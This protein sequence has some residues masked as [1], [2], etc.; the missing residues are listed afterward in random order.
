M[1]VWLFHATLCA[2]SL[3]SATALCA[4]PDW[5]FMDQNG[6]SSFYYDRNSNVTVRE[7]VIQV[8]TR[9][10]YSEEG[11]KEAI[12]LLK[13]MPE[14]ALLQETLYSYEIDCPEREGHLL[15]SSHLDRNGTILKSTD[16]AAATQWEYLPDDTRMGRVVRQACPP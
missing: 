5:L 8:R 9:V 14:S 4:P 12:K 7:G 15:A 13:G 1:R 6:Q 3:Y 2:A 11:R 10:V 16:L